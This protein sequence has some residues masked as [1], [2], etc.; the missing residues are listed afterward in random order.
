MKK[1]LTLTLTLS[2]LLGNI[3]FA[4]NIDISTSEDTSVEQKVYCNDT[5]KNDIDINENKQQGT[6]NI[7]NKNIVNINNNKGEVNV[8]IYNVSQVD[9]NSKNEKDNTDLSN[10]NSIQ[11]SDNG[12][13]KDTIS[14]ENTKLREKEQPQKQTYSKNNR[15][16]RRNNL[17]NTKIDEKNKTIRK[18]YLAIGSNIIKVDGIN[19]P[20]DVS[21]YISD[22]YTLVPL[23]IISTIFDADI[24]WNPN[25]KIAS[26]IFDD[27]KTQFII[28]S[29]IMVCNGK[30]SKIPKAAEISNDRAYVPLRAI[31]E[32]LEAEVIWDAQD[33]SI[34]IEKQTN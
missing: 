13:P 21:P 34:I 8:N 20:V 3:A 9:I 28:N 10:S 14:E 31:S 29:D 15:L 26:I 17:D 23:R 19:F 32:M 1:I 27:K 5:T 25:V 2:V 16:E 30:S 7:T 22:N 24:D 6:V 12:Q 33:K 4:K 11:I 18:A